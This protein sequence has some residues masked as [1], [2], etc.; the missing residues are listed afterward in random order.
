[1]IINFISCKIFI[2]F[3]NIQQYSFLSVIFSL[4]D[5]KFCRLN[6][7]PEISAIVSCVHV[8]YRDVEING[9]LRFLFHFDHKIKWCG[10]YFLNVF[11]LIFE[12]SLLLIACDIDYWIIVIELDI[13][14][15][16]TF[17]QYWIQFKDCLNLKTF[18]KLN[19][20]YKLT[21][22]YWMFLMSFNSN[23][24]YLLISLVVRINC[25]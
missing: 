20:F 25:D 23:F 24:I 9:N 2:F 18:S 12:W 6:G 1:L 17:V 3:I 16:M 13:K 14:P 22:S 10:I 15:F 21:G 8:L 11:I 19:W 7:L 5:H 4:D